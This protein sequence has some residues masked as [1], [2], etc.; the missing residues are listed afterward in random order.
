[1]TRP[2]WWPTNPYPETIFPMERDRYA[3][4][5][6][7]ELTRTALS[8]MLGREFWDIASNEIWQAICQNWDDETQ[9]ADA[10]TAK[11]AEAGHTCG[12]CT[13]WEGDPQ[14]DIM[15]CPVTGLT[16][17]G[18]GT[19]C[20]LFMAQPV[21]R[22]TCGECARLFPYDGPDMKGYLC[23]RG[24]QFF[25]K[26]DDPVCSHFTPRQPDPLP[27]PFCKTAPEIMRGNLTN[28]VRCSNSVCTVQVIA[29][30][31]TAED[32]IANWNKRAT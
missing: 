21:E 14:F 5:V 7:D 28:I 8:G 9:T 13:K 29:M 17:Y 1:M 4:I 31:V 24:P 15:R 30:G 32:A 12:E 11:P 6:P 20:H 18:C 27:C 19:S 25:A 2:A 22:H 23:C 3:E 10:Q 16:V 26:L